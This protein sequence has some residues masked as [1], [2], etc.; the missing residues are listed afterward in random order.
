MD[1]TGLFGKLAHILLLTFWLSSP[2]LVWSNSVASPE[3]PADLA[4]DCEFA[5]GNVMCFGLEL[6]C[7]QFAVTLSAAAKL[8]NLSALP[9]KNTGFSL[10]RELR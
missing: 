2:S 3:V 5:A 10:I 1:V 7:C 4:W 9:V 6:M 8:S